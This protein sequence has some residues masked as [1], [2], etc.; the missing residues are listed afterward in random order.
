M[1]APL[2]LLLAPAAIAIGTA[3]APQT[4]D[5]WLVASGTH[6]V[7]TALETGGLAPLW[8][9]SVL[10]PAGIRARAG[11]ESIH[12]PEEIGVS[13]GLAAISFHAGAAGTLSVAYGHI[14][15]DD[16]VATETS[17][18]AVGPALAVYANL[19]SL[20]L[21]RAIGRGVTVGIAARAMSGRL[22]DRV[23]RRLGL[24]VGVLHD[25]LPHL[26]L[27]AATRLFDPTLGGGAEGASYAAGAELHG[28]RLAAW[29][30]LATFRARY[31]VTVLHGEGA[32]HLVSGGVE[33]SRA[34][35]VDAGAA[36]ESRSGEAV[37]RSRFALGLAAGR[38]GIQVARDGGV[39]DFGAT[40]RFSLTA[41]F[42]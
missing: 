29:G 25:A 39:N 9:P 16:I 3:L 28:G 24:D 10:L 8:T 35:A 7:P 20:G 15:L 19:A 30:A 32:Q 36:R 6:V 5:L 2:L 18:E 33:L 23:E 40:Y 42:P 13:G 11:I 41:D 38:Y 14:G 17:P 22:A 37:W 27:G 4:G 26:R 21:A 1:A 12:A 34:L 31:G